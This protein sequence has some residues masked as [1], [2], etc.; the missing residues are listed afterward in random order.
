MTFVVYYVSGKERQRKRSI[1]EGQERRE[2]SPNGK[3]IEFSWVH[4]YQE[5]VS[6]SKSTRNR[7]TELGREERTM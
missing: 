4:G 5:P 6:P 1:F 7:R 2:S 3:G